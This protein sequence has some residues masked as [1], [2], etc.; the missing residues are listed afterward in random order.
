MKRA[1]AWIGILGFFVGVL[2]LGG[3][4]VHS[5]EHRGGH[6]IRIAGRIWEC[7]K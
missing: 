4:A 6:M 7:S 1:A 2:I 3:W 5:C